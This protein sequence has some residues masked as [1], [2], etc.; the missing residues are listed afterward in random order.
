MLFNEQLENGFLKA[1]NRSRLK[2]AIMWADDDLS[3]FFPAR[4]S[5]LRLDDWT[6]LSQGNNSLMPS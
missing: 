5:P 2:F 1:R 6:S 3:N 4:F